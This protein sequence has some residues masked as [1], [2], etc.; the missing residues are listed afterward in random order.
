MKAIGRTK[1]DAV[2]SDI[3]ESYKTWVKDYKNLS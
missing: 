2:Y 3:H 1:S